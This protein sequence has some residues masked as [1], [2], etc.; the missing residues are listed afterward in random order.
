MSTVWAPWDAQASGRQSSNFSVHFFKTQTFE[1]A[2]EWLLRA[3]ASHFCRGRVRSVLKVREIEKLKV[4]KFEGLT[5]SKVAAA[6]AFTAASSIL[7]TRGTLL[8]ILLIE[9]PQ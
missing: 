4:C 6:A 5:G 3:Q 8:L 1:L 7:S 2:L 9:G